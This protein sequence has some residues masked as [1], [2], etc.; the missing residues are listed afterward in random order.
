MVNGGVK[1]FCKPRSGSQEKSLKLERPVENFTEGIPSE[2]NPKDCPGQC[3]FS[4]ILF[5]DKKGLLRAGYGCNCKKIVGEGGL[6]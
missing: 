5:E 6:Y 3:G 1:E 2:K 4:T